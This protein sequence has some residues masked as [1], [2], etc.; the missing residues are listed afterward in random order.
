MKTTFQETQQF[1][2]KWIWI[3][4]IASFLF[5]LGI[6][7][8]DFFQ[9]NSVERFDTLLIAS[10]IIVISFFPIFLLLY[11]IKLKTN[12]SSQGVKIDFSPFTKKEVS[13]QEV[14]TA[15]IID[16]GFV[17]GWGVR[18]WTEYGTVYNVAGSKGL[19][20]K[21]KN[22]KQFLIGSQKIEEL[23]EVLAKWEVGGRKK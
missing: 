21:L 17:G 13:W 19:H 12:I 7:A 2:Q 23:S 11:F 3:I 20:I 22:G 16:Y 15:E 18:L 5:S 10:I 1:K 6:L 14:E 9:D 4:L 8:I